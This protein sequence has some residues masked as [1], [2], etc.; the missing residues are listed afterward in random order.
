MVLIK[1]PGLAPA[2]SCGQYQDGDGIAGG[3]ALSG[4]REDWKTWWDILSWGCRWDTCGNA[5]EAGR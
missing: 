2:S 1:L 3:R 5:Q 4:Q